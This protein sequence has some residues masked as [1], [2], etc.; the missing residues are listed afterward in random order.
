MEHESS[1]SYSEETRQRVCAE[2]WE[3]LEE[4]MAIFVEREKDAQSLCNAV[5]NAASLTDMR[6]AKEALLK[7]FPFATEKKDAKFRM[8]MADIEDA[9]FVDLAYDYMS[10]SEDEEEEG[11]EENH[12]LALKEMMIDKPQLFTK[13]VASRTECTADAHVKEA[14][15]DI[16][17]AKDIR[18]AF[19]MAVQDATGP[20]FEFGSIWTLLEIG[21]TASTVMAKTADILLSDA[22]DFDGYAG[23]EVAGGVAVPWHHLMGPRTRYFAIRYKN[24]PRF[25]ISCNASTFVPT[26]RISVNCWEGQLKFVPR[27]AQEVEA[28]IVASRLRIAE[29][30]VQMLQARK[31][32]DALSDAQRNY[33]RTLS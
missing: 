2:P 3:E 9:L 4:T 14:L 7:A 18:D 5:I 15:K 11:E 24:A 17:R 27:S 8:E 1:D 25:A 12:T 22:N 28:S 6:G 16:P 10:M 21:E 32:F 30:E 33:F 13:I 20:A 31:E 29:L 26:I 19:I 23:E